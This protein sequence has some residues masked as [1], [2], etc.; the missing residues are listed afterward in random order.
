[1]MNLEGFQAEQS[2][3]SVCVNFARSAEEF[4]NSLSLEEGIC[5]KCAKESRTCRSPEDHKF[6]HHPGRQV[7]ADSRVQ[8]FELWKSCKESNSNFVKGEVRS[9]SGPLDLRERVAE[10]Y[11][12][13]R[14][15]P[16][17][18]SRGENTRRA[19]IILGAK[20]LSWANFPWFFQKRD[21]LF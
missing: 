7:K 11:V 13:W 12:F 19:G 2:Y 20:F 8:G 15:N 21:S 10:I 17:E 16:S 14:K 5:T 4:E 3:K 1:M 6:V 9:D 18:E